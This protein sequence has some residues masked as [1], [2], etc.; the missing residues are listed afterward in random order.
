MTPI[1]DHAYERFILECLL[2]NLKNISGIVHGHS[3]LSCL[4]KVHRN[5]Y[6]L[7]NVIFILIQTKRVFC[8]DCTLLRKEFSFTTPSLSRFGFTSVVVCW[9]RESGM[10]RGRQGANVN[11]YLSICSKSVSRPPLC[12]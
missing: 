2:G 3:I 8:V 11:A 1:S 6:L 10:R 7:N 12:Q 9:N 4:Q 5:V